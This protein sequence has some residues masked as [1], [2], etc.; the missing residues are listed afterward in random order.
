M[1]GKSDS[2][3][4]QKSENGKRIMLSAHMDEIGVIATHVDDNGFVRF[5]SVGGVFP[6][7]T[8][9]GR[10]RFLNGTPGVIGHEKLES[11]DKV[12]PWI[13]STSTS[14]PIRAKAARYA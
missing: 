7:Y 2:R 9:A 13:N 1:P 8:L 14:A 3:K 5:T 12:P 4:G 6:A 11:R 10:V